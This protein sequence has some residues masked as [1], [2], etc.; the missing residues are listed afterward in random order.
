MIASEIRANIKNTKNRTCKDYSILNVLRSQKKSNEYFETMLANIDLEDIIALKLELAYRSVGV[1][2]YGAPLW[3]N[4]N[5]IIKEALLKYVVSISKSKGE[6]A[7]YV[8]VDSIKFLFLL[9]K[10]NID[11]FFLKGKINNADNRNTI[12]ENISESKTG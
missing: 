9:K 2:L 1:A 7:R 5:H 4:L 10:Y 11:Y 8:G 12:K 6:A 3:R